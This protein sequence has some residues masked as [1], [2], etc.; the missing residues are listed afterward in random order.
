ME[1]QFDGR[2]THSRVNSWA[3]GDVKERWTL[4]AYKQRCERNGE[5]GWRWGRGDGGADV[6]LRKTKINKSREKTL[7][8]CGN[9]EKVDKSC[10]IF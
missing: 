9:I 3:L 2:W 8:S 1:H 5:D 6:T 7:N 10:S 4:R